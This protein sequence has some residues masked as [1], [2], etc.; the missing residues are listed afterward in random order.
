MWNFWLKPQKQITRANASRLDGK[1]EIDYPGIFAGRENPKKFDLISNPNPLSRIGFKIWSK[2]SNFSG[3]E[4]KSKSY[5][6]PF[7]D[8]ILIIELYFWKKEHHFCCFIIKMKIVETLFQRFNTIFQFKISDALKLGFTYPHF[9]QFWV[10]RIL[11]PCSKS[12]I[13]NTDLI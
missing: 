6:N 7:L 3:F 2:S 4:I 1:R 13:L 5:S 11:N 10:N 12:W 8:K 9:V